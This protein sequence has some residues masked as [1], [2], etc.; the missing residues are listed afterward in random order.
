MG[1]IRRTMEYLDMENFRLLFSALVRPHLEYGNAVWSPHL[2]KHIQAIENVQR[3]ATKLV[4]GLSN[5]TYEQRLRKLGMPSLVYR[6]YRGDMIE[7]FK[8]THGF[9]DPQV[10]TDFLDVVQ[11]S[12]RRGHDYILEKKRFEK[13]IR[14]YSFTCRVV[15]QWNNLPESVVSAKTILGFE[16]N[17]DRL[18]KGSDVMYDHE[19]DVFKLTSARAVRFKLKNNMTNTSQNAQQ[20]STIDDDLM[21]EAP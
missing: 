17:L 13:D 4:P 10:T 5:L 12:G 3:R 18:W 7:V 20:T 19:C 1:I 6:R 14:K 8:I 16:K 15:N 9:Y 21:S 11:D 2:K